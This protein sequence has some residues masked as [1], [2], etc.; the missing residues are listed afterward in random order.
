MDQ[1]YL[2]LQLPEP[3][4]ALTKVYYLLNYDETFK[5]YFPKHSM[6]KALEQE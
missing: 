1:D 5:W 6:I 3:A 2:R 4:R